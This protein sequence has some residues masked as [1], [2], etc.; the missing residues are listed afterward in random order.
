M[1]TVFKY[2]TVQ[3]ETPTQIMVIVPE[4]EGLEEGWYVVKNVQ[5]FDHSTGTF[6]SELHIFEKQ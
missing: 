2:N 5:S 1:K 6:E 4:Q 3:L